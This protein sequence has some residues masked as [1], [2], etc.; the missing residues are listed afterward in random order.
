MNRTDNQA[1][2]SCGGPP[3][4]ERPAAGPPKSCVQA[5][6]VRPAKMPTG[7]SAEKGKA[8]ETRNWSLFFFFRIMQQGE[9]QET[10]SRLKAI[11][12]QEEESGFR[13]LKMDLAFPTVLN[14][15]LVSQA[16]R[17]MREAHER[18]IEQEAGAEAAEGTSADVNATSVS[19][20]SAMSPAADEGQ[21]APEALRR[22]DDGP[23]DAP[24]RAFRNWLKVLLDA[25]GECMLNEMRSLL[26]LLPPS[27]APEDIYQ[28]FNLPSDVEPISEAARLMAFAFSNNVAAVPARIVG[29]LGAIYAYLAAHYKDALTAIR[30]SIESPPDEGSPHGF[31]AR[32]VLYEMLRQGESLF[33]DHPGRPVLRSESDESERLREVDGT[34]RTPISMAFTFA[35]LK[36]LKLDSDTL[37]SFPE[38]FREGMAARAHRLGDV[39]RHAPE[40]WEGELGLNTVHGFFTGASNLEVEPHEAP[41]EPFWRGLRE[42]IRH[43]NDPTAEEG[44]NLRGWIGQLFR[45]LGLE[46]VHIE[47]GQDP[48]E[49]EKDDN[50]N[51]KIK[52]L[53]TRKEHFGFRDGLSQ[54]FVDMGLGD[55]LP[56][57]G[58]ADRRG[59]WSPVAPGEIFLDREDESGQTHILPLNVD[60]REGS[61]YLVFRKLEQDVEGFRSFLGQQ[62]PDNPRGQR[63]L[64]AQFVGRWENGTSLVHSPHAERSIA[65]PETEAALNDFRYAADDP[66]G[67]KCPLGAHVRRANPRD[68]GGRNDVRHHRILRRG[69]AYGGPLLKEGEPDDGEKRGILFIA[70]NAR[71]DLQFEVI[72]GDWLNGG[73]FLG[74][75][76]LGRCPI[77]GTQDGTVRSSFLEAGAVA[78]V[79]G[80][81]NFVTLRGGDYFFAPGITALRKIA[82][83]CTF[84]PSRELP[85]DGYA[86]ADVCPPS[87]FGEDRLAKIGWRQLSKGLAVRMRAGETDFF[88]GIP[89]REKVAF[90]GRY[91][92]VKAV[93]S[94]DPVPENEKGDGDGDVYFSVEPYLTAGSRISRGERFLVGLDTGNPSR[95]RLFAILDAAWNRLQ[96]EWQKEWPDLKPEE[97]ADR[98][99]RQAGKAGLDAALRRT[100]GARR[101]DLVED[102]AAQAA[103]GVI[104]KIFGISG[105]SWLSE[106]AGAFPFS[107]QHVGDLPPDWIAAFKGE[108]PTDPGLK[109]MQV[110]STFLIADLIGNSMSQQVLQGL[111]RQAGSEMLNHIDQSI[112]EIRARGPVGNP[113]N[114]VEAFLLTGQDL[115]AKAVQGASPEGPNDPWTYYHPHGDNWRHLYHKDMTIILLEIIGSTL[116]VIPL[117]FGSVMKTL[118]DLRLDLP[119]MLERLKDQPGAA[120]KIIYESERL[121]PNSAIR[122]RRCTAAKYVGTTTP[123]RLIAKGDFVAA[124]IATANKDR[125]IFWEPERF[126]LGDVDPLSSLHGRRRRNGKSPRDPSDYLMFGVRG[127]NKECWGA[128]RAAMPILEECLYAC[129][130]L[131][132]LRPVA[133]PRGEPQKIGTVTVGLPARF[134]RI[135][136]K[137]ARDT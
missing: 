76:G 69:I 62:R 45:L 83:G 91:N 48:Y 136:A 124:L 50:D 134:T 100:A 65:G 111:S 99:V 35:G 20:P 39:G 75:A 5:H 119:M 7:R 114:L 9:M 80:L 117:T 26:E 133:G 25:N 58:T 123:R 101:I 33:V 21:G 42:D 47:L 56:G 78:P 61:T 64:A 32:I 72:Q 8:Y 57:G 132:G 109:T 103:Y 44:V 106:L 120:A 95:K 73:E 22:P 27:S 1:E 18:T 59:T 40:H 130:R 14:A 122:I 60:L 43:F 51:E 90:V 77:S 88:G 31:L 131:Q 23:A 84:E 94:N 41:S 36:A 13:R 137:D 17:D 4:A 29:N 52:H 49:V 127:S 81:P 63:K 24:A 129:G 30:R 126:E 28:A 115:L 96:S 98:V 85:Y 16:L 46:V 105:P 113:R 102:L 79:S 67:R 68:I 116:A 54:P 104:R 86:I 128:D 3:I 93:L 37:A 89:Q 107:R 118:L 6:L 19:A 92:D 10:L 55:T 125:H 12:A 121:N 15:G 70:A 11:L 112:A 38:P 53:P 135:L 71:I 66:D 97:A 34:D 74:Q 2:P 82:Q 110:W 108:R 87:L